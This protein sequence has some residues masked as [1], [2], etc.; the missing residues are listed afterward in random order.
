MKLH[1]PHAAGLPVMLNDMS[2][3]LNSS[4]NHPQARRGT[5]SLSSSG[6]EDPITDCPVSFHNDA[7]I[8]CEI[9][10]EEVI[11]IERKVIFTEIGLK[12]DYLTCV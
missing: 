5:Y 4:L 8:P 12:A 9:M 6:S 10:D 11:R 1:P 7:E 2:V 3:G